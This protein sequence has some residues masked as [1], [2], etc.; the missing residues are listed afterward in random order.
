[1]P[2]IDPE[3]LLERFCRY[4]R[5]DTTADEAAG[6]A[7]TYPSTPGQWV[8]AQTLADELREMGLDD[9]TLS[10]K[11]IV[12]G[13][14]PATIADPRP[15][16][17]F[18]AHIDTSPE[19][20]GKNVRPQVHRNYYGGDLML[21]DSGRTLSPREYPDLNNY[22]GKTLV[23]SDGTTL[24]GADNKAGVAA[25]MAAAECLIAD[26]TIPHGPIRICFTCDEEIGRGVLHVEK[27]DLGAEVAYTLDGGAWGEIDAETFSADKATVTIRG[28]NI[29][30]SIG[31]GKMVNAVRLAGLFLDRLPRQ[32]FSPE[33]TEGRQ[34]FLHPYQIEGGV[35][36]VV[37]GILLRDF[38]TANL[39]KQAAY[40]KSV[41]AG[42]EMEFP[43]AR[44]EVEVR[45]Q[46]RNMAD[47]MKGEP[48]AVTFAQEAMKRIGIEPRIMSCRG[49][50]DGSQLTA[51]GLPTPNLFTGEH[52][53]HSPY[54]WTCVEEIAD[55]A[56]VVV[57]LAR[58]WG[59]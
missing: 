14:I 59:E 15:V 16:V 45:A 53:L 42:L 32:S 35:D 48:R 56:R 41:A 22:A 8:L 43:L 51:K 58:R 25:I 12:T 30:P 28:V 17:A 55:A 24:L 54:E 10:D 18:L 33:T 21:G 31:K 19:T 52:N 26:K 4:A 1:M 27:D 34:G 40:L 5:I 7:G 36:T 29:H 11:A 47:G 37:I 38:V 49:G 44:V 20:T 13:T 9:V 3:R 50:T 39:A 6:S 46:Y 57:E 23:T 2:T